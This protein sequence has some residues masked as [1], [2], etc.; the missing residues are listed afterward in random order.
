MR[1]PPA[2][3]EVDESEELLRSSST[4]TISPPPSDVNVFVAVAVAPLESVMT[5]LRVCLPAVVGVHETVAVEL[6]AF[7]TLPST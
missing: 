5:H 3:I 1:E 4:I 2:A 7:T 6:E